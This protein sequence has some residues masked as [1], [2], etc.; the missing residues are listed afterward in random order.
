MKLDY[1]RDI[2]CLIGMKEIPSESIDLV[3]TDCPYHIVSGGSITNPEC[4]QPTGILEKRKSSKHISLGGLLDDTIQD[5]RA[6]KL[7]RH[8]DIAFS[9]WLPEVYR[10]LKQDTHC[11]IMINGRNLKELQ[12]EAEKVGFKF[13]NLLVWKKNS[14][15]PNHFYMQCL[16]F[17]LMLRKGGER[18]INDMGTINCLSVPNIIGN[19]Q[20]PT[21]KPVPL[22][23]ILIENSSRK[24]DVVLDPFMGSGS[25]AIACIQSERHFVGYEI[26]EQYYTIACRRIKNESRQ[27]NIFDQIK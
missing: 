5:V 2:D 1:I 16:E 15:T 12:T 11:Y 17:I 24:G 3:V 14:A 22:M 21:Q 7:F 27:L 10:V 8:N 4:K 26:D 9:E 6:G 18:W 20:H 13:Q 19:K 23:R 25:T